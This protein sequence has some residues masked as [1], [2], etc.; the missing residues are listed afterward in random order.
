DR[1][2]RIGEPHPPVH[3]RLGLIPRPVV[4]DDRMAGVE[5]PLR[6]A[7]PHRAETDETEGR[8][9]APCGP[10]PKRNIAVSIPSALLPMASSMRS[11]V[12]GMR[13]A[14]LRSRKARSTG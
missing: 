7:T 4:A 3:E 8:H 2:G 9:Q 5:Q 14:V 1:A 11:T 13:V 12:G 10:D 6:H